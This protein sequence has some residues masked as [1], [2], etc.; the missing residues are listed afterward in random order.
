MNRSKEDIKKFLLENGFTD[1]ARHYIC[2]FLVGCGIK[3]VVEVVKFKCGD[4]DF[5]YFYRWFNGE[6]VE[7]SHIDCLIEQLNELIRKK[8]LYSLIMRENE[9][10]KREVAILKEVFKI[11]EKK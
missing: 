6:D 1:S 5:D 11:L 9:D 8:K 10:L 3:E 4:N 2:G 7:R